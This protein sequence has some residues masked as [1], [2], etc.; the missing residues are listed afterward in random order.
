M[1]KSIFY[2]LTAT[3]K[4]HCLNII[5]S[6]LEQSDADSVLQEE[7]H[8]AIELLS[9]LRPMDTNEVLT[10]METASASEYDVEE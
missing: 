2:M 1:S 5:Q 10:A 9:K 7:A 6:L 3:E 8:Q 4:Q